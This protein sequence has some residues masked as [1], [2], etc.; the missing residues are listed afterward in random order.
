M[1]EEIDRKILQEFQSDPPQNSDPGSDPQLGFFVPHC[2]LEATEGHFCLHRLQQTGK[3]VPGGRGREIAV[4]L[5]PALH[6]L[7]ALRC[8]LRA[9]KA[10]L[11]TTESILPLHAVYVKRRHQGPMSTRFCLTLAERPAD[12]AASCMRPHALTLPLTSSNLFCLQGKEKVKP[13]GSFLCV[14]SLVFMKSARQSAT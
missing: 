14:R 12:H 7:A 8:A 4:T 11:T 5:R 6:L 2:H 9:Q 3:E 1:N 13:R 10:L